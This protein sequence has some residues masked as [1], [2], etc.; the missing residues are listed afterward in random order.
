MRTLQNNET[1]DY[2]RLRIYELYNN[3]G[4]NNIED[5][6]IDDFII[7]ISNDDL[8]YW[9]PTDNIICNYIM[10]K[11]TKEYGFTKS[12][13]EYA[14]KW[15]YDLFTEDENEEDRTPRE[16]T[17]FNKYNEN[18]IQ[19][20]NKVKYFKENIT[21]ELIKNVMHPRNFGRLWHFDE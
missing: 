10:Y 16:T 5:V 14:K 18:I 12:S 15:I 13:F 21:E 19:I 9:K 17:Y 6:F 2:E 11:F 7:P 20:E 4:G 8:F 3:L 1:V